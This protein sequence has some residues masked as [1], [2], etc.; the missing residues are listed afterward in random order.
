MTK[1]ALK[2]FAYVAAAL[3]CL[4]L[5]VIFFLGFTGPGARFLASQV[6]SLASS[7]EQK[8][9][10]SPIH[11]LLSGN[12]RIDHV[13]I[14]DKAGEYARVEKIA[15]D[16]SPLSLFSA[17]FKA[18]QLSAEH[19]AVTRAP[20]P[21]ETS[22]EA[23]GGFSLPIKVDIANIALPSIYL[24]E[25]LAGG[26]FEL[27]LQGSA[28]ANQQTLNLHVNANRKD[29][30]EA[31]LSAVVDY[32]PNEDLLGLQAKLFEPQGGLIAKL[33]GLTG[34]PSVGL[35]VDGNGPLSD[36]SGNL[37]ASVNS[38]QVFALKATHNLISDGTRRIVVAGG[39]R[40]EQLLP[41]VYHQL[42]AGETQI[43]LATTL[44]DS[45]KVEIE[46]ASIDTGAMLFTA[47]GT[48]DPN[49]GNNITANLMGTNGAID[50]RLPL[51]EGYLQALVNGAEITLQGAAGSTRLNSAVSVQT[52]IHPQTRLDDV[53]LT[54]TSQNL[55][56][57]NQSGNIATELSV[58]QSTMASPDL[59]R[60]LKAPL[61]LTA[62]LALS[63]GK[64]AFEGVT[65]ESASIGGTG[66]GTFDLNTS[67]LAT[68]LRLFIL[69]SV[70]PADIAERLEGTIAVE[71]YVARDETGKTS[72]ENLVVKSEVLE[73]DG[74]LS[75]DGENIV[76]KIG[77]RILDLSKLAPE[78]QGRIGFALAAD[79]PISAPNFDLNIN[80][81]SAT[82]AGKA[83]EALRLN[84]KGIA[85]IEAPQ[86]DV[87]ASGTIDNQVIDVQ[88]KVLQGANGTEIPDLN[89][90]VG[91]NT[92]VGALQLSPSFLPTGTLKFDAPDVGLLA[93]L[94]AQKA[95]GSARGDISIASQNGIIS[96]TVNAEAP[97]I[98]SPE[99]TIDALVANIAIEDLS[100]LIING[101]VS[102]IRVA[103]SGNDLT[104]LNLK[105]QNE[106]SSTKLDLKSTYDN[107]PLSVKAAVNM[108]SDPLTIKLDEII[109]RPKGIDIRLDKPTTVDVINGAARLN[110]FIIRTGNGR[111]NVNGSAGAQ[112]DLNVALNSLPASLINVFDP[113][114]NAT[115]EISGKIDVKGAA[116]NPNVDYDLNWS[117][118]SLAQTQSV[119]LST[120]TI[121]SKGA[122]TNGTLSTTTTATGRDGL[123]AKASGTIGVMGSNAMA[124]NIEGDI[125]FG[126]LAG[127]TAQQGLVVNGKARANITIGGTTSAPDIRGTVATDKASVTDIRRNL[128][129][130]N[131]AATVDLTGQ[132]ATI[133]RLEGNVAGGGK[134]SGKGSVGFGGAVGMP[135]S[136]SITLDRAVYND[137]TLVTTTVSGPITLTGDLSSA[138]SLQGDLT[139]DRT[140]IT[141][142]AKLPTSLTEID[143]K[144]RNAPAAVIEQDAILNRNRG[145][146]GTNSTMNLDLRVRSKTGIFVRGRGI[147]AQLSGDLT[148]RGT[149]SDPIVAGGFDMQ[150][151][152][153]E[154]LTRRLDFSRG[155]IS[156]GG[157]L[158]PVLDME[159]TSNVGGNT[160]GVAVKGSANDPSFD[161]FSNPASPQDEVLA[162][163]IFGQ[164]TSNLSPLQIAQLADAAAQLAGGRS[165]S[166]LNSL[167]SNLGI[168]DLDVSTTASGETSMSAG[169]YINDRTYIKLEQSGS[170]GAKA[171]IN[172]D[173]GRGVKLKGSAGGSTGGAAGI[174][175]EKEY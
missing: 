118:A 110:N 151:G 71:A 32:Q 14:E 1:T 99:V 82:L 30:P 81:A 4:L 25:S 78:A 34:E 89:L 53:R 2:W 106:A 140:S 26:E 150:R 158:I 72:V 149:A 91:D 127:L 129:I 57:A 109:A 128:T 142:P 146:N 39:G 10:I 74:N 135:V 36:W 85:N 117:N 123:S 44:S 11:G 167:R 170:D 88:A 94:A 145:G 159:A 76:A 133:S 67:A 138:S 27:A 115:G 66:S 33:I 69:P 77:G 58:F 73:A 12:T 22:E 95:S 15:I 154:I 9:T 79:G 105:I 54:A 49:G 122:L 160:V 164:S 155:K 124:L 114:M 31:S 43:D 20:L 48:Y 68:N 41:D 141:I 23:T 83:L 163:L 62:P 100:K 157:G 172:L 8:I 21:A 42:F 3:M 37:T 93:A 40:P 152:R 92:L 113:S 47:L 45:G 121:N 90:R 102:A 134:I 18:D 116:T 112:L 61:K 136:L 87:T 162:M 175:Y 55:D 13:V 126:A 108:S 96:A 166:L 153:L 29:N 144:R 169:R 7:D 132:S 119:G 64:L 120:L 17:T 161:F 97:R 59:D 165:T 28:K 173:I 75:I 51:T 63:S 148:I 111:I 70:L 38:N 50:F 65:L 52:L 98:T 5:I 168:D 56:I 131:L 147:D 24:G 101:N 80:S 137:G 86:A 139:I 60:A 143:I 171:S 35:T 125:P 174:F 107:A 16:W 84:A 103:A 19:I 6:S 130:N 104:N 46:S 156:F